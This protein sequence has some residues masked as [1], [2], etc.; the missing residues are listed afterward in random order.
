MAMEISFHLVEPTLLVNTLSAVAAP[1]SATIQV[2]NLGYPVNACYSG[3]QLVI[4]TGLA[5]EIITVSAFN[6]ASVPPTITA[7]FALPHASGAQLIGA[8]FPT[9][10]Q[11]GDALFTQSEILSYLARAQ[12]QFLADVPMIFALNTQTVQYGQIL[13]PLVCDSVEIVRV[14]SSYQNV[15][16]ASLTRSGNVVTAVSQS[17]HGLILNEKFAIIQSP[18]PNFD[19]A[20]RVATVPDNLHWTYPQVGPNVSVSG[21]G[22][23]GLWLRLLEVS[24]SELACQNPFWESQFTTSLK[25]WYED[26]TGLYAFGLGGRPSSNFPIEILC[27]IRDSDVLQATD[28]LLTPDP[29]LHYVKYKALEYAWSKNGEQQ[30]PQ[31]AAYAKARYDRGVLISRR[32]LGWQGGL[33]GKSEQQ[34]AMAGASGG[35]R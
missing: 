4:D 33:G 16:L 15:A 12:N 29:F 25:S 20:F 32:W 14:S 35:R 13:Q 19:G 31:L 2:P 3:A 8:T 21:G 6:A 17:P 22:M 18:D 10:A 5:E 9:Q 34:M 27:S 26:R 24:Q 30:N 7:T 11:S 23:A 1:G 28:G